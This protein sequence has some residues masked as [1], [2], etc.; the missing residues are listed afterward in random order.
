M[1][2]N[3]FSVYNHVKNYQGKYFGMDRPNSKSWYNYPVQDF[4]YTF[5]SW[6]FRGPEYEDYIGKPVIVCLGDS[7]TVNLGGP[8]EHS[9]PSLLAKNFTT[10]VLNLAIN[11]AGNDAIKIVYNR[12][13]KIFDVIDC[14]VLYSYLHRRMQDGVFESQPK[15]HSDNMEYFLQHRLSGVYELALPSSNYT[16]EEQLFFDTLGI[17]YKHI[18]VVEC[19][20]N[21]DRSRVVKTYYEQLKGSN[22]PSYKQ[23]IKGADPHPDMYTKEFGY[24]IRRILDH[25]NRDGLHLNLDTNKYYTDYFYNKWKLKNEP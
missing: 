3:D 20:N 11:G 19:F 14:F 2:I 5:N 22:W 25:T 17:H 21:Q 12:A 23:F 8:V 24:F 18:D 10:P 7:F 6:G 15:K 13:C 9:W 4:E 16:A 1:L